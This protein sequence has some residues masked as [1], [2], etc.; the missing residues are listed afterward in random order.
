MP[1]RVPIGGHAFKFELAA[2]VGWTYAPGD[3]IIGHLVRKEPIVTPEAVIT[4]S[5]IGRVKVKITHRDNH[6]DDIHVY[7]DDWRLFELGEFVIHQGPLHLAEGTD[8]VLSWPISVTIPL[9]PSPRCIAGHIQKAS[10]VPLDADHPVHHILPGSFHSSGE[11]FAT[12]RSDDIVEYWLEAKLRYAKGH[13][14]FDFHNHHHDHEAV[15]PIYMRH[16]LP[17]PDQ[18]EIPR[19]LPGVNTVSSQRLLP[20][21]EDAD[22]SFKQHF[23]KFFHSSKVPDF[24]YNLHFTVPTAFQLDD[25]NPLSIQLEIVQDPN[26]TSDSIKDVEQHIQ[27]RKIRMSLRTQTDDCAPRDWDLSAFRNEHHDKMNLNLESLFEELESPLVIHTGK[28]NE[29]IHIGNIFQLTLHRDGLKS[30]GRSLHGGD[31]FTSGGI[32]PSFMT[33]NIRHHHMMEWKISLSIAGE[34]ESHEYCLPVQIIGPA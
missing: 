23:Q 17:P 16:P 5:F 24:K 29:P 33:Y 2:P 19:M 3:V 11:N 12:A 13:E 8:E 14:R 6:N 22:L 28:R 32:Q 15:Q 18:I 30:G 21:M 7:R 27:I 34:H 25:P 26:G 4:L 9:E 10:F 1:Q 31:S 20:G